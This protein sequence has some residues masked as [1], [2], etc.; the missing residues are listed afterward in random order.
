MVN[1]FLLGRLCPFLLRMTNDFVMSAFIALRRL[2][3][4]KNLSG[5]RCLETNNRKRTKV[6][7]QNLRHQYKMNRV[8]ERYNTKKRVH[9]EQIRV[10]ADHK[11]RD[12][13]DSL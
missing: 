1:Y 7:A 10:F 13:G 5:A 2:S 4:K 3:R 9:D 11:L 12:S 8:L 6:T